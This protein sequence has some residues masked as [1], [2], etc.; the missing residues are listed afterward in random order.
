MRKAAYLIMAILTF[1]FA[2][3]HRLHALMLLFLVE[4][5]LFVGAWILPHHLMKNMEIHIKMKGVG[6]G[7]RKG[8]MQNGTLIVTNLS[9]FPIPLFSV[10]ME[11][12]NSIIPDYEI[13]TRKGVRGYAPGKGNVFLDFQVISQYCGV[14]SLRVKELKV[15]D[16][17]M[18]F[19]EK[20]KVDILCETVVLPM[21]GKA[22]IGNQKNQYEQLFEEETQD[23]IVPINQ[24]PEMDQIRKYQQGDSMKDIHWKL[25]ARNEDVLSKIYQ[26]DRSRQL[27]F[28]L[29]LRTTE[30]M[31]MERMDAFFELVHAISVGLLKEGI[32]QRIWWYDFTEKCVV[33]LQVQEMDD[34]V[35]VM[36]ELIK[37]IHFYQTGTGDEAVEAYRSQTSKQQEICLD[38]KLRLFQQSEFLTKFTEKQYQKELEMRWIS[39]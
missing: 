17:L 32:S 25:S 30:P 23:A 20:K 36:E 18:L 28:F 29:D 6:H 34:L 16:Y 35:F 13:E 39:V 1:Y 7:M 5:L 11:F 8:E 2:G 33:I 4:I 22:N 21:G 19:S 26:E 3:I 14:F 37:N 10:S 15:Y 24:P 31:S 27:S 38:A 9:R 12:F